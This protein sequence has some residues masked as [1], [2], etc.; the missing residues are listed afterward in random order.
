[1]AKCGGG[2]VPP[3]AVLDSPRLDLFTSNNGRLREVLLSAR[4]KRVDKGLSNGETC[5]RQSSRER[6]VK[7]RLQLLNSRKEFEDRLRRYGVEGEDAFYAI[8]ASYLRQHDTVSD[9]E[10]SYAQ[11]R[12]EQ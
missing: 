12:G 7:S 2:I 9:E 3:N 5:Q 4:V 1:M 11:V 8:A 6:L 10:P